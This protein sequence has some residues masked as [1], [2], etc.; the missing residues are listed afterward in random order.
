[1]R[2]TGYSEMTDHR[3]LSPERDVQQTRF[4]NGT[5]ITVNFGPTDFTLPS[6]RIVRAMAFDL[7]P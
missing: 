1:V 3:F 6:G 2:D 7:A 4:A 5:T